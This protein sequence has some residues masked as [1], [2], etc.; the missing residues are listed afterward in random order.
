[1]P[2]CTLRTPL[3]AGVVAVA[4]ALSVGTV[5]AK[6][7]QSP[8]AAPAAE[9]AGAVPAAQGA[10]FSDQELR[11]FA[12]VAVQLHRIAEKDRASL[13]AAQTVAAKEAVARQLQ[14]QQAQAATSNGLTVAQYNAISAAAGVEPA[15]RMRVDGYLERASPKFTVVAGRIPR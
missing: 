4:L 2:R 8:G 10:H 14:T 13:K 9:A 5:W 15:L 6:A 3:R 7:P 12:K 11:S 1:M